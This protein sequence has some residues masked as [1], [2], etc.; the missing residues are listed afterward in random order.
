MHLKLKIKVYQSITLE[1]SSSRS[2]HQRTHS[3]NISKIGVVPLSIYKYIQF[4]KDIKIF[5]IGDKSM[6]DYNTPRENSYGRRFPRNYY[7]AT[8]LDNLG[9]TEPEDI[10][11]RV[12][13]LRSASKSLNFGTIFDAVLVVAQSRRPDIRKE[14]RHFAIGG[15][16]LQ[17]YTMCS[18]AG[19]WDKSVSNEKQFSPEEEVTP[20]DVHS[21]VRLE[22]P[23]HLPSD[24]QTSIC[25]TAI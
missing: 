6:D 21:D 25:N 18:D 24:I 22:L 3:H 4:Y 16:L 19:Y 2:T 7:A 9:I 20:P 12:E 17:L 15:G 13:E 10:K 14:L 11:W 8:G 1:K 5:N 23:V